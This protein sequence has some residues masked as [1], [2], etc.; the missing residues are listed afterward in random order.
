MNDN[1]KVFYWYFPCTDKKLKAPIVFWLSGG[2][3]CSSELSVFFENGP[4]K[5]I[6]GTQKLRLNPYSW[7]KL[8]DLVFVDFPGGTGFSVFNNGNFY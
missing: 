5:I 8:S 6:H 3:G 2:P 1:D 4:F 7:N